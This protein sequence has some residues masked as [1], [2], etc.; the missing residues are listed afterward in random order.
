MAKIF[1]DPLAHFLLAGALLFGLYGWA[2]GG[3]SGRDDSVIIVNDETLAIW[4][5]YRNKAFSPEKARDWLAGLPAEEHSALIN[6]YVQDEALY[7]HALALGLNEN[8]AIIRQRLIQKMDYITLG[9]AGTRAPIAEAEV[10]AYFA[11][12]QENYRT[13]AWVTLTHIFFGGRGA[14]AKAR[15]AYTAIGA[16]QPAPAGERF[17]F[18]KN[19]AE[20]TQALIKDHLGADIAENVFHL[21]PPTN[22]WLPPM[23]SPYGWHIVKLVR[24]H[25]AVIPPFEDVAMTVLQDVQ[26]EREAQAREKAAKAILDNYTVRFED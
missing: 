9:M 25:G 2:N 3:F 19:Y 6:E 16:G 11:E 12:N 26:R 1:R 8:D 24:A 15:A 4:M 23:Q 17:L 7:R 18:R 22:V 14:E 10:R 5:Q 13:E 21:G 20:A